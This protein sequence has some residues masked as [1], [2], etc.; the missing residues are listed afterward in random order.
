M[1]IRVATRGSRLS[2][3]QTELA[4]RE[5]RGVIPDSKFEII[6]VKTKGDVIKDKPLYKIGVKGVFEK[7][8]NKKVLD[9][10]ADIAVHSMKDIPSE[11][12]PELE[13]VYIPDRGPVNDVLIHRS[14]EPISIFDLASGSVVGTSSIRRRAQIKFLRDDL[15]VED[16]RGNVDTRVRKLFDGEYDAIV[17]A[18]AGIQRLDLNIKYSRLPIKPFTPAPGQGFIAVVA[19]KDSELASI[20]KNN[21][22]PANWASANAERE[23]IKAIGAGC[24]VPIGGT[25]LYR[26]GK[27]IFIACAISRDGSEAHWIIESSSVNE[28]KE[29]GRQVGFKIR[30]FAGGRLYEG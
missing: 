30:E 15:I 6:K 18:E 1:L 8:V 4:L 20:L 23:F 9:G 12:D 27:L 11:L 10:E 24:R 29:L 16:I 28:Y 14:G 17:L 25:C 21:V 5:I 7:E 26:D 22:S 13:I 2:L 3:I 19:K